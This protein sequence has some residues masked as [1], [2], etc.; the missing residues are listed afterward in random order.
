MLRTILVALDGSEPSR[1]AQEIAIGFARRFKADI[2]G[3]AVLDRGYITAPTAV[4]IG[5]MAF[6]H[7][8]DQVKLEQAHRFL[9][10][11]EQHFQA[12]CED[13]GI[14][15]Q[16]I[17]EE[18]A[19]FD[20][21]CGEA[22]RHDLLVIGRDTDFHLE[23]EPAVADVVFRLLVENP[24]PVIVCPDHTVPDGP[25]IA[26]SDGGP[27]SSRALHMLALLG[28][29]RDRVIHVLAT[30]DV[31]DAARHYAE[32]PAEL[33]A[34]H[35]LQVE[36]HA[37]ESTTEP[38]DVICEHAER[39]GAGMVAIGASSRGRLRDF[40]LGSTARRLLNACPCPLFVHH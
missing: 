4:G 40:F 11:L 29:G 20:L 9:E 7:H 16:V 34:R 18:G 14:K 1:V 31:H 15:W 21:I 33:L 19:P 8:R 25:I 13:L 37:V 17:E 12:S 2:T 36:V 10:R 6:K 39:L 24:R 38:H 27:Q 23:E 35:G 28:L 26:A 5:G 3:L 32:R 30:A 22:H